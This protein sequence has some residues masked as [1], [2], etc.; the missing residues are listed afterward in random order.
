VVALQDGEAIFNM[1]ASFQL[2]RE[3]TESQ[4]EP[5]PLADQPDDLKPWAQRFPAFSSFMA[6]L[7]EQPYPGSELPT[8]LWFKSAEK[9]VDEPL[10]HACLLT[11]LS[12]LST[13][14]GALRPGPWPGGTSLDHAVW[15]HRQ[16]RLDEWVLMDLVP[17]SASGGRGWYTG[18]V[19]SADGVLA[20]SLAQEML[21]RRGRQEG[22]API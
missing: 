2:P 15:F 13:G 7:P 11:Y 1:S 18:T 20:A 6:R 19:H 22:I 21:F 17:H 10:V 8:R 14:L 3:G 12:D 16:V 5:P 4:P 9:L